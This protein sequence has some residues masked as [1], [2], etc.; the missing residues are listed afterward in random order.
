MRLRVPAIFS[1]VRELVLEL[2][3]LRTQGGYVTINQRLNAINARVINV[4]EGIQVIMSDL[5][6]LQ[7]SVVS[8]ATAV[9][10]VQT[11][12]NTG[13]A[14]LRDLAGKLQNSDDQATLNAIADGFD[15]AATS[16]NDAAA[17]LT[18][19]VKEVDTDHSSIPADGE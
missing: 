16:L 7:S 3:W 19:V 2:R 8:V 5:T 10:N 11:G 1:Y 6:R 14:E 18:A 9:T 13:I 15:G 12:V 4:Q 17:A